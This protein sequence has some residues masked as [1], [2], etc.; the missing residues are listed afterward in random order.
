[1]KV[2]GPNSVH[3]EFSVFQATGLLFCPQWA[4]PASPKGGSI[5]AFFLLTPAGSN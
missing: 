4:P 1:M 3:R 2:K 5:A